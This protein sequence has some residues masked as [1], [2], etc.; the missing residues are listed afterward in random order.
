MMPKLP[1]FF[2][3][4]PEVAAALRSNAPV[5][6]LETAV[7]THGLPHPQN[8]ELARQVEDEVRSQGAVPATTAILAGLVHL[9][10]NDDEL[11]SLASEDAKARKISRRD[12]GIA[13]ARSENGGTT[14]AG[15]LIAARAAGLRVFSTGGIGGVH[16]DAPFDISADLPELARSPL[17]VVCSGAK[18][19]LDLPATV[20]MLETLG[21]PILG[22]QTDE[23][24]AFYSRDSGLSVTARV[25]NPEEAAAAAKAQWEL[26]L[27]SAV[28]VVVPPPE[29]VAV[30]AK[31]IDTVI[32]RA[33]REAKDQ[34]VRGAAVTPFLLDRVSKLSGGTSLKV[35]LALLRNNARI[36]AQI[37]VALY[38]K[39]G[40]Y[41]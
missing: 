6:A 10:L 14:V 17:L 40:M 35:N 16:R 19:I 23:L 5:V 30:P 21:V 41:V 39:P 33:L 25:D 24:P 34:D 12:Y 8:L 9:G 36:A 31:E 28:L 22:Y 26:G 2:R 7:V 11:R 32:Q 15:T 3:L 29:D 18:A 20:E 38:P 1:S 13:I 37:A 4:T 27:Q